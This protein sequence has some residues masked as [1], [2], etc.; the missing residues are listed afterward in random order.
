MGTK[1]EVKAVEFIERGWPEKVD[2]AVLRMNE[3]QKKME[4][5]ISAFVGATREAEA[6][7]QS[8]LERLSGSFE[9]AQRLVAADRAALKEE[10]L[11]IKTLQ[12]EING[13]L[14]RLVDDFSIYKKEHQEYHEKNAG[15]F[16]KLFGR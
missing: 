13:G 9:E 14:T 2:R 12:E 3:E 15:I 6:A 10:L 1:I 5:A 16:A 8:Q 7:S 4:K 11:S